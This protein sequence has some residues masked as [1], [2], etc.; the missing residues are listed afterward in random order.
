MRL[1][2]GFTLAWLG[3]VALLPLFALI[4]R[5]V[6]LSWADVATTLADARVHAA[7]GLSFGAAA[8]AAAVNA[9]FGLIVAWVLVR[10]DF[11]GRR[12]I[13]ALVDLPFALPT[14]VAGIALT[15]VW[16]EN[17]VLGGPLA[18]LG[19]KVAYTPLGIGVAL[20][21]IGLPFVVRTLQPVIED[22]D[23]DVEEAAATLGARPLVV[24]RRVVFPELVPALATGTVLAF[25]RGL[26]EYGSVVFISGNMP[27]RTEILPLLI[28]TKLE[29]YD[30]A[31][32]TV[33]A[34]AML[35]AS[36]LLL[37]TLNGLARWQ[38]RFVHGGEA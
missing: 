3:L 5:G 22:L 14:A 31:G 32:A 15:A 6:G 38:R 8:A 30:Y 37:L 36:A 20:V 24:F 4:R 35:A 21:F 25:A 19:V 23:H 12:V 28:V 17:G 9:V 29:Q 10:H 26:G 18:R 1:S 33:L 11:V 7:F 27:L 13:D 34:V 16:S 2:L